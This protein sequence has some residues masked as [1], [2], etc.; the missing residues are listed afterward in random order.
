VKGRS[1]LWLTLLGAYVNSAAYGFN[2]STEWDY[3]ILLPLA[4]RLRNPSLYPGDPFLQNA[5]PYLTPFWWVVVKLSQHWPTES[6]LFVAFLLT[7]LVFFGALA[8]LVWPVV[9]S[10]ALAA[11]IVAVIALSPA[12]NS[13]T[14]IGGGRVLTSFE[15][16]ASLGFAILL[17]AGVMLVERR[18]WTAVMLGSL[19]IY[20]DALMF[21]CSL[22]AFAVFAL[23]DWRE[24]KR[25]VFAA[26]LLGVILTAP[27]VLLSQHAV[28]S[29]IPSGYVQALLMFYPYQYTLRWTPASILLRGAAILAGAAWLV[30]VARREG[31]SAHRRLE[32]LTLSYAIP[33]ALGIFFGEFYLTPTT[34]RL[35]LLRSD[36]FLLLYALLLIQIYGVKLLEPRASIFPGMTFLL[37]LSALLL[38]LS[39][40]F[41]APAL[42]LFLLLWSDPGQ[43][44]ERFVRKIATFLTGRLRL[45]PRSNMAAALCGMAALI[46]FSVLLARP[47]QLWNFAQPLSPQERACFD[48]QLW[49]K[50]HTPVESRFLVPTEGCGFEALSERI[51]WGEWTDG[52]VMIPYPS[53]AELFL[54]RMAALGVYP[55]YPSDAASL[56]QNYRN[57]SWEHLLT[58]A[59]RNQLDY[60][61]QFRGI[62]SPL[63]PA[64]QNDEFAVYRVQD[65][66]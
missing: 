59:R 31:I 51:T 8:R 40:R 47:A 56:E 6:I 16:H 39:V 62:P 15:T 64:Y 9:K 13:M 57:Q 2:F 18:W 65:A 14:S 3:S 19:G 43:R 48:V 28:R 61:I 50:G 11:C 7:K 1:I 25:H 20:L 33:V 5:G 53:L 4:N 29:N 63:A 21:L 60:V 30:F 22:F 36:S 37:G 49:M 52:N 17:L 41:G 45:P 35:H 32:I 58:I 38:A 54:K 55:G 66:L 12:L 46:L 10:K 27:W 23:F 44:F 26:G 24:H 42:F 34:A